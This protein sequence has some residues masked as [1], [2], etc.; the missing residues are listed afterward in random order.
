MCLLFALVVHFIEG[1]CGRRNVSLIKF[2]LRNT[3]ETVFQ[4]TRNFYD[5]KDRNDWKDRSGFY[6]K[7]AYVRYKKKQIQWAWLCIV[8]PE[9]N[10][11]FF[12]L[13]KTIVYVIK[14][15]CVCVIRTVGREGGY[16]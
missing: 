14:G 11:I 2:Y 12:L 15:L 8:K 3:V 9:V 7:R 13:V 10:A 4:T 6:K 1:E 5:R 16:Y